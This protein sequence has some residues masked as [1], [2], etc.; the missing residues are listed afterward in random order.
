MQKPNTLAG[1]L[2]QTRKTGNNMPFGVTK[3]TCRCPKFAFGLGKYTK[4]GGGGG[5]EEGVRLTNK[6]VA[7]LEISV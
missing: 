4:R 6:D 1:R 7:W 2:A 5:E 3:G